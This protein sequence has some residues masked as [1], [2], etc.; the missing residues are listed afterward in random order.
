MVRFAMFIC[1]CVQGRNGKTLKQHSTKSK[2]TNTTVHVEIMERINKNQT[3]TGTSE[4]F[5]VVFQSYYLPL[6]VGVGAA[7]RDE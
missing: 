3:Q 5:R 7:E 4:I 6:C 2:N 1:F